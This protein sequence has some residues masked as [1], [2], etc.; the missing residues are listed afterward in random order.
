MNLF[1]EI[2]LQRANISARE[3]RI[4]IKLIKKFINNKH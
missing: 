1:T 3:R 4:T 2:Q